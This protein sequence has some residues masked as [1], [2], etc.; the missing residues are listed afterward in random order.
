MGVD[1][2]IADSTIITADTDKFKLIYEISMKFS[3]K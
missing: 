1:N 2:E 3:F